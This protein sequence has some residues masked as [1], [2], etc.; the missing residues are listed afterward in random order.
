MSYRQA[1]NKKIGEQYF[2]RVKA[3]EEL[4]AVV[5]HLLLQHN[6][7]LYQRRTKED[8]VTLNISCSQEGILSNCYYP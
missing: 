2:W 7:S 5:H 4:Q 1:V 6:S 3:K 8:N